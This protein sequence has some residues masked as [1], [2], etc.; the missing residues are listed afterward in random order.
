M[1]QITINFNHPLPLFPLPE[2]VLLPHTVLPLHVFEPRYRRMTADAL[3]GPG[4]IAPAM[5]DRKVTQ[6]EYL[7]SKP[8]LKPH[9]CIGYIERYE[10][11][12]DG[13]Y[14]LMLRGLCRAMIVDE[15]E[16]DPYRI[17]ILEPVDWP[18]ATDTQLSGEREQLQQ[19]IS[20]PAFDR[21]Q[22]MKELRRLFGTRVPTVG[23]IDLLTAAT[24]DSAAERYAMLS[25]SDS[26]ERAAWLLNH[27]RDLRHAVEPGM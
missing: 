25:E 3:D 21:L 6:H 27:L 2:T 22:A 26:H 15:I 23:L 12:D 24:T 19:I 20:D 5:F 4:L 16:N 17:A 9:V 10:S 7:H 14:L 1:E 13:R 18:P 8:P 11:L